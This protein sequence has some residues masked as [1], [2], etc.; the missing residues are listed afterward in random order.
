MVNILSLIRKTENN[1]DFSGMVRS[2]D[3][4]CRTCTPIS[5][6]ECISRCQVYAL[7]NELRRLRETMDDPN[8]M[9]ELLN[10]LKNQTRL[11]IMQA[12][13]KGRYSVSQLQKELKKTGHSQSQDTIS[14]EYLRLLMTVGLVI[15]EQENYYATSFGRRLA[16]LLRG[17]PEFAEKLPAHSECCE[18]ALLQYLLSG[19]KTFEDVKSLVSQKIAP[20]ILKRLLSARLIKTSKERDYVFFFK[21][22]RDPNKETFSV[23]EWK[24]YDAI[25]CEGI[26]AGKLSKE[27]GLSLRNIYR[28]L[29]GLKGKK[30]VFIRRIPKAYCLTWKGKKLASILQKLQLIVEDT[31]NSS[32]QVMHDTPIIVKV[33]G[34]SNHALRR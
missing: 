4:E 26:S 21:S 13:A 8:Y 25:F 14:K 29:R 31:W 32:Q 1:R 18:E 24:I 17:F 9:K 3:E 16:E 28:Y 22:K 15:E 7:K 11:H 5:P 33:G 27:T 12:V 2:L 6:L 23:A 10:A 30:L 19:P 20:R 34:L